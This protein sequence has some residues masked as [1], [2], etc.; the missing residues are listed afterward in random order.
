MMPNLLKIFEIDG[1]E[2]HTLRYLNSGNFLA[3]FS[4]M[5][6]KVQ[7]PTLPPFSKGGN[8]YPLPL[9]KGGKEGFLNG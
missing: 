4:F 3:K 2:Y 1:N 5:K 9:L 6:N 7:N 8:S